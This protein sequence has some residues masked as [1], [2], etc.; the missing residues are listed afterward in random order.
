MLCT[1]V[2]ATHLTRYIR[3][4]AGSLTPPRD[5]PS[6]GMR[7][8]CLKCHSL[9]PAPGRRLR[10]CERCESRAYCCKICVDTDSAEH[11]KVY[12]SYRTATRSGTVRSCG[13]GWWKET[14]RSCT[15][16]RSDTGWDTTHIAHGE[17]TVSGG[18][19]VYPRWE[20]RRRYEL[21]EMG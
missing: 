10:Q 13:T 6:R 19:A 12:E 1:I 9:V 5:I 14:K 7:L 18:M 20:C 21:R 15:G 11:S 8:M 4:S 3:P 17:C 16:E 2:F